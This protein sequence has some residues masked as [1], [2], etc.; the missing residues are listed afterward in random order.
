MIATS[1]L[2]QVVCFRFPPNHSEDEPNPLHKTKGTIKSVYLIDA[3][4]MYTV[5]T[6]TGSLETCKNHQMVVCC[7]IT[8]TDAV[9][10]IEKEDA[11]R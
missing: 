7:D 6:E 8:F 5:M 9:D 11:E 10:M 1:L 4:P 2:N 3:I